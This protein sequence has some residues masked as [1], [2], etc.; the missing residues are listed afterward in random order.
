VPTDPLVVDNVAVKGVGVE[1]LDGVAVAV[2]AGVL[3][4]WAVTDCPTL[5]LARFQWMNVTPIMKI[6][7]LHNFN[8]RITFSH[9]VI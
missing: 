8:P 2:G 6:I 3:V 9:H 1:V 5:A 7:R 4:T